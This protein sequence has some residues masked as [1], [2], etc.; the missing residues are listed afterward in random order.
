MEGKVGLS[1]IGPCDR[2]KR[3]TTDILV[4]IFGTRMPETEDQ[5][6][7]RL[8]GYLKDQDPLYLQRQTLAA[9]SRL[10]DGA[11]T[12]QLALRPA[13]EKWSTVEILAH[14][15]EDELVTSWRYRQMIE[16]DGETLLGFDQE[17]WA[18]LGDYQKWNA[19]EALEMFR[20]L[21]E[22]NLRMLATLLPEQWEHSGNHAE[23]GRITVRDLARHMAAHDI[24]HLKQI[25]KLL[26]VKR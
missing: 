5:Y 2:R 23:R 16:H 20:L 3:A 18:R 17:L 25:E 11:S 7:D 14:L 9:L 4:M 15:A 8:A 1:S 10:I 24:N 22:A 19:C 12:E 6:R 13:P 26:A 21:R